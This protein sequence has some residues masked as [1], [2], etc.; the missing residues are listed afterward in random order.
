MVLLVLSA[1]AEKE[2]IDAA[3]EEIE[4]EISE[5]LARYGDDQQLG[6]YLRSRR[7][8][9]Y[10]RMT[11]RNR[12]LVDTLIDRALGTDATA[13]EAATSAHEPDAPESDSSQE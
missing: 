12:K 9:S 10:L 11:L 2:G 3:D 5:Q 1:I 7:G 4:A 6:E 13:G 8:R